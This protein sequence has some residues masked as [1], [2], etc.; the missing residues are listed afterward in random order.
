MTNGEATAILRRADPSAP[1]CLFVPALG[2]AVEVTAI[3]PI[4]NLT[5]CPEEGVVARGSAVVAFEA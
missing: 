3:I 5:Y 4:A 1:F 2:I